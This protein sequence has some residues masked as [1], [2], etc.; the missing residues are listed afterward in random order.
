M[1]TIDWMPEQYSI[2]KD[3]EKLKFHWVWFLRLEIL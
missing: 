1:E 2:M 3:E